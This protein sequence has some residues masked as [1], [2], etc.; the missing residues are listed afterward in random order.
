M[1]KDSSSCGD[2]LGTGMVLARLRGTGWDE[3]SGDLPSLT[4]RCWSKGASSR[5]RG[6]GWAMS[7]GERIEDRKA[8]AWYPYYSTSCWDGIGE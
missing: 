4:G 5:P 1:Y 2:I 6:L 8:E 7:I 3:L